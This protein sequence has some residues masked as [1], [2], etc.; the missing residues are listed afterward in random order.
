[1]PVDH[2]ITKLAIARCAARLFLAHGVTNTSGKDIAAAAGVSERTV[3]RHFRTKESCVE[4][5]LTRSAHRFTQK[6]LGWSRLISIEDHLSEVFDLQQEP[7]EIED[8]VLIARLLALSPDEPDLQATWLMAS[9]SSER[10]LADVIA[11]RLDRLPHD[12]EVRL[13]AASVCAA[14]RVVDEEICL[15][16]IVRGEVFT[17][18]DVVSRVAE[19]IR[20]ASTLPFCDPFPL[21]TAGRAAIDRGEVQRKGNLD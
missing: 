4:P 18:S 1:L 14:L 3:W 15:A 7:D 12:Y 6:M 9:F 10:G 16:A 13:C 20:A 5:L 17:L 2:D 11:A 8:Y 21:R 19:A